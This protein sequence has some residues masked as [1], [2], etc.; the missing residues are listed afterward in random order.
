VATAV[1]DAP[2]ARR[3]APMRCGETLRHRPGRTFVG[4]VT[5]IPTDEGTL[6]LVAVLDPHARRC[7]GFVMG[8]HHKAELARVA[9]CGS[10]RHPRRIR[11]KTG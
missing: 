5:E 3:K 4:W 7:V 6:Y 9:L 10:H 2:D 1:L 8:A 11:P